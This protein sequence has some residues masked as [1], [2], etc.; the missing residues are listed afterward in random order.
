MEILTIWALKAWHFGCVNSCTLLWVNLKFTDRAELNLLT[1]SRFSRLRSTLDSEMKRLRSTG[2][3]QKKKADVI[4]VQEENALWEKTI[5]GDHCPQSL[6]DTL[7]YYIGPYFAIRGGEHRNLK[8]KPSQLVLFEPA[9]GVPYLQFTES[10]SK[11]NQGG[12][13]RR[14]KAPKKVIQHMNTTNP[15]RCLVRLYKL[16]NSKCPESRPDNAF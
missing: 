1:D 7:V 16:Y 4:G 3:F 14:K 12:L 8:Y 5:L 6:V 13:Q 15:E 11:T 10:V 2:Q 9:D